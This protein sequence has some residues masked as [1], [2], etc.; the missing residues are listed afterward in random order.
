MDIKFLE[1]QSFFSLHFWGEKENEDSMFKKE[2]IFDSQKSNETAIF[3]FDILDK[4]NMRPTLVPEHKKD[5]S[6]MN[7]T[8][9]DDERL[10]GKTYTKRNLI[11]SKKDAVMSPQ[12]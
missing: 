8:C 7:Y 1:S 10:F 11:Q 3:N 4:K 5:T 12:R 6:K 9:F 2:N